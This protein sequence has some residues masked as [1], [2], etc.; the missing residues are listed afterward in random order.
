[1]AL[2]DRC[3]TVVFFGEILSRKGSGFPYICYNLKNGIRMKM[4]ISNFCID[5][6]DVIER[7]WFENFRAEKVGLGITERTFDGEC[8]FGRS[9]YSVA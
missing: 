4:K 6:F 9:F 5:D 7:M 3:R 2:H 1:M 8:T